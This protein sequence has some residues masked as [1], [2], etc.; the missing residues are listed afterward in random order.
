MIEKLPVE[1]QNIDEFIERWN[2]GYDK[3]KT[4][5]KIIRNNPK[6]ISQLPITTTGLYISIC[7]GFLKTDDPFIIFKSKSDVAHSI[8]TLE[9]LIKLNLEDIL[10]K[11]K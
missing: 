7:N 8:M 1:L 6:Y 9:E 5:Y 10:E 11:S 4:N 2:K 3:G